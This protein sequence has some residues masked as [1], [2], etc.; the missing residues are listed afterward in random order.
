MAD[1][2]ED[3]REYIDRLAASIEPDAETGRD[4]TNQVIVEHSVTPIALSAHH[5]RGNRRVLALVVAAVVAALL[6][7]AVVGVSLVGTT[8]SK[9]EKV[10]PA[11][12]DTRDPAL[13]AP[14]DGQIFGIRSAPD[15]RSLLIIFAGIGRNG[16]PSCAA[17]YQATATEAASSVG[18]ALVGYDIRDEGHVTSVNGQT[19]NELCGSSPHQL[20]VHLEQ[21]LGARQVLV[22]QAPARVFDGATLVE[23]G[24]LPNGWHLQAQRASVTLEAP[25]VTP[26]WFWEW[27]K[28]RPTNPPGECVPSEAA[29]QLQQSAVRDGASLD[30][31]Q[32]ITRFTGQQLARTATIDGQSANIYSGAGN[33]TLIWERHQQVFVLSTL[34]TCPNDPLPTFATMLRFARALRA[35]NSDHR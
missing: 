29:L 2:R 12:T 4:A 22:N 23:P 35:P 33:A 25:P 10:H 18:I 26:F 20:T 15:G 16:D 34:S 7:L 5:R 8:T 14:V 30:T 28:P 11:T 6:V 27:T 17:T 13:G 19:V 3:L 1:L 9:R 21:P 32:N 24:W 31:S